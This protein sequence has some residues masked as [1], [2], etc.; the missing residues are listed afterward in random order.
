MLCSEER[1]VFYAAEIVLALAY[2]HDMGLMYR[3]LK[4]NNVLLGADGHVQLVDLGGVVD[5]RGEVLGKINEVNGLVPLFA[6]TF[7]GIKPSTS[8]AVSS[9]AAS[10]EDS[11]SGA[12]EEGG[13]G[14][15]ARPKRKLSIMG[16]F[17]YMAPEMVIMLSQSSW[18]MEGYTTAVDWWSLGVT[19]FKLL[20]GFRP[21]SERN[22]GAFVE[23]ATTMHEKN[24][25]QLECASPEYAMLFQE[26]P[27]PP[28]VSAEAKSMISRLLDVNPTTRLGS[29][30]TG[31]MDIKSHPFFRKLDWSLLELVRQG[32]I[33]SILIYYENHD[34]TLLQF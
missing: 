20:T 11:D 9:S 13:N 1:V 7:G 17:G 34:I 30:P 3:D 14:T 12:L 16:T 6:Q 2:L 22:F 5:Q 27:F 8:S 15:A 24:K 21:F 10:A 19:I 18:Q 4:P 31:V 32:L 33:S 29:G 26:V 25:P 23:I 28:F